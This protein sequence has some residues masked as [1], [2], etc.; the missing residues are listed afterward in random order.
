MGGKSTQFKRKLTENGR[1]DGRNC[2]RKQVEKEEGDVREYEAE[3]EPAEYRD[4][5]EPDIT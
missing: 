2:S 5:C 1:R 4:S 3:G